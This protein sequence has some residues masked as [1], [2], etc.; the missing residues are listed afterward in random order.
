[1]LKYT[2]TL[3]ACILLYMHIC[4]RFNC[5]SCVDVPWARY[6]RLWSLSLPPPHTHTHTCTERFARAP[7]YKH[8]FIR[9]VVITAH[10]QIMIHTNL[11]S[12]HLHIVLY[13][14]CAPVVSVHTA[15]AHFDQLH[16]PCSIMICL[17]LIY[18]LAEWDSLSL[19]AKHHHTKSWPHKNYVAIYWFSYSILKCR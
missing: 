12:L 10:I 1:M 4:F 6:H 7:R 14:I 13:I 5:A 19:N 11:S 3:H 17:W 16:S 2:V 9:D 18:Y 8:V 15:H